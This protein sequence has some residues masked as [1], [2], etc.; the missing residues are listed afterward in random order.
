[1][2]S[3][4]P[5][6]GTPDYEPLDDP[7][8]AEVPSSVKGRG[9]A[10]NPANR[11]EEI[12][13]DRDPGEGI[14]ETRVFR[15]TS[16]SVIT[17][18]RSP[19]VGF[20]IS[21]NPY[22]GCEHGCIYCYARPYHEYLGLSAGLDFETM[23]FAKADAPGLL[24]R[25]L[26]APRY[27]P[28]TLVLS[29]ITDPYQPVEKELGI[30]RGCLEV[31]AH[32]GNP[33]SVITKNH[34]VTRDLD[35]LSELARKRAAAVYLSVTTLDP[36]LRRHME[37]RTSSPERRLEAVRALSAAGIPTGVM[38]APVIPGLTDHEIPRIL[39]AAAEAGATQAGYIVLRLP[40]AVAPLFERWLET[41]FP[42]RRDK[43]LNRIRAMR[44]GKLNDP[45]FGTRM[46]GE[47]IF[48]D[49]IRALFEIAL[50]KSGLRS[51][52]MSLSTRH[53][54]RPGSEQMSL[55]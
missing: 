51:R 6:D 23:L 29:G 36:E 35:I 37:P 44:G 9:A 50:R 2:D 41:H 13:V 25:E 55:F 49:E 54:R 33:V 31:L 16:R 34:L 12:E 26:S 3:R 1:M 45:R 4:Q 14:P 11:F 52:S 46:R 38:V 53:F 15:D 48:A 8:M 42:G 20:E 24:A 28:Q 47:G 18:N 5:Q 19:D 27:E 40:Y 21:V 30:T 32:F 17:T 7:V 39:E 43:V 22:R 10:H